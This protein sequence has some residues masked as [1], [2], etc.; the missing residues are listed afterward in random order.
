MEESYSRPNST[1]RSHARESVF[2][3]RPQNDDEY[4]S[5][6]NL[7]KASEPVDNSSFKKRAAFDDRKDEIP[8]APATDKLASIEDIPVCRK[9]NIKP[10]LVELSRMTKDQLKRVANLEL[11]NNYGKIEWTHPVNLVGVN[12]DDWV[13]IRQS[14][15]E[16]E[17]ELACGGGCIMHFYN[18][19]NYTEK[20]KNPSN[21][22]NFKSKMTQ[23]LRDRHLKMISFS[24]ETGEL[25]A[26]YDG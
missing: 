4:D 6:A 2:S 7:R 14:S 16:I 19:G 11:W 9:F 24:D 8:T 17:E 3:N 20:S 10:S 18:F 1:L 5:R 15:V 23:W 13:T 22:R 25:V 21:S 26:T 12:L